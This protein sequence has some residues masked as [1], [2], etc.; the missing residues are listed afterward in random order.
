MIDYLTA[1]DVPITEGAKTYTAVA[2]DLDFAHLRARYGPPQPEP[3]PR[4]NVTTGPCRTTSGKVTARH[5]RR[6]R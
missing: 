5:A 1:T 2:V 6:Q 4:C 3:C